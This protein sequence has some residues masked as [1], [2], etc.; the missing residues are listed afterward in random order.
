M[1]KLM[2]WIGWDLALVMAFKDLIK[3]EGDLRHVRCRFGVHP[4]G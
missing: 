1:S 3:G 4:A 2:W